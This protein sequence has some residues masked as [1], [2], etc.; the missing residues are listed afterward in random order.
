MTV[1]GFVCEFELLV[2]VVHL[3][4]MI[5]TALPRFLE[6]AAGNILFAGIGRREG[7]C[8]STG[9]GSFQLS[10]PF[11]PSKPEGLDFASHPVSTRRTRR[12]AEGTR[13]T[14]VP[15]PAGCAS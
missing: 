15:R 2:A 3:S 7:S 8:R 9:M 10:F 4:L 13:E 14:S 5:I 1:N 6:V 11:G 12:Q